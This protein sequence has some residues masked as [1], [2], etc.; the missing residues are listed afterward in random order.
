[1]D[2]LIDVMQSILLELQE[3]N[4]KLDD[5]R[6]NGINSIDDI[7]SKLEGVSGRGLYSS[8]SDVCDKLDTIDL[9][10]STLG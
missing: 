3:M 2:E 10:I 8:L 1:M 4:R 9:S 5:I 6:G 7:C